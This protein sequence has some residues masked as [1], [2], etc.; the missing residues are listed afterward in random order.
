MQSDILLDQWVH[1]YLHEIIEFRPVG[2]LNR[3]GKSQL[4]E[5]KTKFETM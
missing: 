1:I 2:D 5:V 3:I 4:T